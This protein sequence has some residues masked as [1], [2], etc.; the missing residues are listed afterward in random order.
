[1]RKYLAFVL[2]GVLTLVGVGAAV[3]GGVQSGAGADLGQAVTNTLKASGYTESLVEKTPQGDQTAN[4]V[5]QSPDRL[6][7][8][9]QSTGRRTY[10]YIIGSI[11]YISVTQPAKDTRVPRVYYTQETSGAD[12]ADPA[13]LYL[14]YYDK[15]KSSTSG[16][17]TTVTL[18]QGG[19]TEKLTYTVSGSYVSEFQAATP[20]GTIDLDITDVGSSPPVNLPAGAKTTETPPGSSASTGAAG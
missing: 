18:S 12:A 13:H 7:G 16:S 6:G 1:M 19:Q 17:V 11:E 15:G 20:G 14:G 10:L 8:W 9:L 3:L 4:V 2:L 5:Y